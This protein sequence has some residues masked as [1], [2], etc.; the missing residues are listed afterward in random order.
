MIGMRTRVENDGITAE[1]VM[2]AAPRWARSEGSGW[3]G[4]ENWYRVTLEYNGRKLTV[5]FGMGS[6]LTDDPTAEDVLNCLASDAS[7]YENARDFD[8]WA[9]EY[10]YDTDSRRAYRTWEQ[11]SATTAQAED[12]PR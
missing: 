12:V 9:S 11:V 2:T 7:G 3:D 4:S 6:G 10:G 1:Y 5:P 8:D